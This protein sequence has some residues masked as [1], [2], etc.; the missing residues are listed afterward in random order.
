[1]PRRT[2]PWR[3]TSIFWMIGA[4][5]G[6]IRSTL[7]PEADLADSEGGVEPA[8]VTGDHHTLENLDL[9][10]PALDDSHVH[11]DGV[12]RSEVGTSSRTGARPAHAQGRSSRRLL[13]D[14]RGAAARPDATRRSRPPLRG[15][16]NGAPARVCCCIR[17]QGPAGAPRCVPCLLLPPLLD[18]RVVAAE[19]YLGPPNHGTRRAGCTAAP[20]ATRWKD[21]VLWMPG[22][23]PHR[24]QPGDTSITAIAAGSPP[25]MTKSPR[26]ISSSTRL[27]GALVNAFVT[28]ADKG[29]MV[30]GP[31]DRASGR[32]WP[33]PGR[34]A[35]CAHLEA[36]EGA[37][38]RLDHHHHP[39]PTA[40]RGVVHLT[41]PA[42]T[43]RSEIDH[44]DLESAPGRSPGRQR[45][46]RAAI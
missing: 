15:E 2:A 31:S 5:T 46:H 30:A 3:V 22:S 43:V 21:S 40:E 32:A 42:Q 39:R 13:R 41:M 29:E 35:P 26:E 8:A 34:R 23:R 7:D 44:L 4:C 20:P 25:A 14:G 33:R 18:P 38:D 28:A 1:M 16:P 9:L 12:A 45:S 37:V 11:L 6:K 27:S 10:T 17:F 36:G 19:Q 24:E